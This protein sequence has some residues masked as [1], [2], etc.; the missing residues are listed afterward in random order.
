MGCLFSNHPDSAKRALNSYL[1]LFYSKMD[2]KAMKTKK[3]LT[4]FN[5]IQ[6]AQNVIVRL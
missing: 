2:M 4:C 5:D 6:K 3:I 1:I